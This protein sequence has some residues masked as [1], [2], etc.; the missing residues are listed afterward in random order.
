MLDDALLP[1]IDATNAPFWE[2]CREGVLRLQQCPESGRLMFP[3][4][5]LNSWS[6]RTPAQWVSVSGPLMGAFTDIAPYNAILVALE[7]DPAIRLV[8]NLVP[9]AGAPINAIGA[10]EIAIGTAVT[11]VFERID[12]NISL[13]RWVRR[14]AG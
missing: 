1:H 6:P 2:G 9:Y 3:P 10:H 4:R 13:P 11:V 14:G 5:P 12:D 8:G 7:E